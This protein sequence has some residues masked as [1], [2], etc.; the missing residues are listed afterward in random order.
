M[1]EQ[2]NMWPF[3][4]LFTAPTSLVQPI[5]PDWSLQRVE[6]NYAGDIAIEKE[7]VAKVASYGRQIGI[8]TDA[9]LA[10]SDKVQE[11][12]KP[13]GQLRE[14]AKEVAKIKDERR[15]DLASSARRAMQSLANVDRRAAE[16]IARNF[17]QSSSGT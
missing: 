16:R 15:G 3:G 1:V 5:L 11:D 13:F 4:P 2:I 17:T 6:V 8:L 12:G 9:V 7:V 14:I 10:L